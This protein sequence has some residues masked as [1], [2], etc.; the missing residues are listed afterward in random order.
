MYR[1]VFSPREHTLHTAV[2]GREALELVAQQDQGFDLI[3]LDLRMPDMDGV[4]FLEALPPRGAGMRAVP[5]ILTTAEPDSSELLRRARAL[6]V[7]AVVRKPWKP[8]EL[9][10]VIRTALPS[11]RPV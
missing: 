3:L 10:E 4:Q 5:V 1:L 6:G 7:A 8:Q 9:R 11:E 2:N